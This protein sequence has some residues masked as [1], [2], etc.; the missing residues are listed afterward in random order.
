MVC[1]VHGHTDKTE[2]CPR[3]TVDTLLEVIQNLNA[4]TEELKRKGK[5]VR[6]LTGCNAVRYGIIRNLEG[7]AMVPDCT[8]GLSQRVKNYESME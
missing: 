6:H 5:Y 1:K 8:C 2:P 3:C 4:E 7:N